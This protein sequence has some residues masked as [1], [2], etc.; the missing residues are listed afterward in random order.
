MVL[1]FTARYGIISPDMVFDKGRPETVAHFLSL[2][3]SGIPDGNGIFE[4][5]IRD[6]RYK[7]GLQNYKKQKIF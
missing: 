1:D 2:P 4:F 5:F 7:S 3:E 6:Y